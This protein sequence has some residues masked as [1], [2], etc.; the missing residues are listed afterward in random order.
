MHPRHWASITPDKPAWIMAGTGEAVSYAELE[1]RANRIAHWLRQRGIG[2]G[3]VIAFM[4][5]N[6]PRLYELVWGAQRAGVHYVLVPA[7]LVAGELDYLLRDGGSQVLVV[8]AKVAER[9]GPA[10]NALPCPAIRLDEALEA[11]WA[12]LPDTPIADEAPGN[13]MLYSSGTTGRPKGIKQA[14]PPALDTPPR[15]ER[16]GARWFGFGQDSVYLSP[17]PLYHAAPLRW[18]LAIHRLGGTVVVMDRFDAEIAL[19]LIERYRVTV[20]QF[21]PTHFARLLALPPATKARYDLSSLKSVFHAGAPCAM[22]VKRAMIDWWG[23]IVHEFYSGTEGVGITV[24]SCDEWIERPGSVGRAVEG[25][26]RICGPDD[27]VLQ[28]EREGAIYFANGIELTYHNDPAQT[29]AAHNSHGW[30][31]LGDIGRVDAEGYLY[32]TDR[33]NFMIISGGVNI[34]PQEI[35]HH[36]AG[37]DAVADVAVMGLPDA[38]MG[39]Q[40]TAFVEPQRWPVPDEAALSAELDRFARGALSP[41][42]VPRRYIFRASLERTD[43]GKLRKRALRDEYLETKRN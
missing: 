6:H 23:P 8:S 32:L 10:L 31:T 4:S 25:D 19:A 29:A 7:T 2:K 30:V 43:T 40:V 21:V 16:I 18:S 35:E 27:A 11:G 33:A 26:L 22:P 14:F 3:A 20:A 1:Q 17:A 5:E 42:K 34:Y 28:A 12:Q 39:E 37:H 38:E 15:A 9:L 24:I 41:V 36:L 13:D